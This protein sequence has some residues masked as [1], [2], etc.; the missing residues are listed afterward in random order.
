LG[1]DPGRVAVP[2][3]GF[4]NPALTA[5]EALVDPPLRPK[6][7]SGNPA[8]LACVPLALRAEGPL[9]A[10]ARM[11]RPWLICNVPLLVQFTLKRTPTALALPE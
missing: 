4:R 5:E 11:F 7:E 10:R 9:Q 6:P 2:D 3:G 8:G 1:A